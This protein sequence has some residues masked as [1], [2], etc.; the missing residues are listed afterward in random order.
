MNTG[1]KQQPWAICEHIF[2]MM[3]VTGFASSKNLVMFLVANY[4]KHH[5]FKLV[6]FVL[7]LCFSSNQ[8]FN[9]N[10][11]NELHRKIIFLND[12]WQNLLLGTKP[13]SIS[14]S[15]HID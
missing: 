1:V 2:F 11:A 6:I 4:T 5:M 15:Y 8:M 3:I 10:F 13:N 7:F 12:K 9:V 14:Y